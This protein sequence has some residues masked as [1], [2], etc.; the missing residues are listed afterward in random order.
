VIENEKE[1]HAQINE[2]ETFRT[3]EYDGQLGD[4]PWLSKESQDTRGVRRYI[5]KPLAWVVAAVLGV[6]LLGVALGTG[7]GIGLDKNK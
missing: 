5:R 7:L 1:V 4:S 2:K 3:Y 6:V